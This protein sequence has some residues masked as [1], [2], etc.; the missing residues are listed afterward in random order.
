MVEFFSGLLQG[1]GNSIQ[2]SQERAARDKLLKA[3]VRLF[4]EQLRARE[5]EAANVELQGAAAGEFAQLTAGRKPGQQL[6]DLLSP[7]QIGEATRLG[8]LTPQIQQQ[9]QQMAAGEQQ[10]AAQEKFISGLPEAQQGLARAGGLQSIISGQAAAQAPLTKEQQVDIQLRERGLLLQ[11]ESARFNRQIQQQQL[12]ISKQSLN[13]SEEKLRMQ[14]EQA[15]RLKGLEPG[16]VS[17]SMREITKEL[18]TIDMANAKLQDLKTTF[19]KIKKRG[20]LGRIAEG[21]EDPLSQEAKT[22]Y[23]AYI[24]S[25]AKAE[26]TGALQPGD[27]EFLKLGLADPSGSFNQLFRTGTLE[28]Q[29]AASEQS[30]QLARN[31]V[32]DSRQDTIPDDFLA[33]I[34]AQKIAAQAPEVKEE[35]D[36]AEAEEI[37]AHLRGEVARIQ[38]AIRSGEMTKED[39]RRRLIQIGIQ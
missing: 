2:Q 5:R 19:G 22:K 18:A 14:V 24:S 1:I 7:Q 35:P 30:L 13:L 6:M 10:Q 16:A 38:E 3:Q 20:I 32:I 23:N 9:F 29:I 37:P 36:T 31:V 26:G 15:A 12:N 17:T 27:L 25:L 33:K 8:A 34:R 21:L 4:E 11:E 28:A 39:A